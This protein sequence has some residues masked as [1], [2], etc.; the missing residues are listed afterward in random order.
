MSRKHSFDI[1][2]KVAERC[3]LAC[4]YCYYFFQEFD[5]STTPPLIQRSVMER[6]PSFL[7]EASHQLNISFFNIILHGGEPLLLKKSYFDE[8][9]SRLRSELTDKV[10]FSIGLQTNGVLIDED[11]IALFAKHHVNVGVSIDGT[12]E[13]HDER[14]PDKKGVGSYDRAVAGLELL[15]AAVSAGRLRAAGA[16]GLVPLRGSGSAFLKHLIDTLGVSSPGLNFPR[17]GWDSAEALEWNAAV[18]ARRELASTWLER[19]IYP[20][21]TYISYLADT[22]FGLMSDEGAVSL[23][24]K[25]SKRHHIVTISSSGDLLIDDNLLGLDESLSVSDAN[26]FRSSLLDFLQSHQW[27]SLNEAIDLIPDKCQ[28][29][30][31]FRTCRSGNL[32]NRYSKEGGFSR[33]SVL[34]DSI[35]AIHE[36]IA[37]YLVKVGRVTLDELIA[38]LKTAPSISA[39]ELYDEI[40]GSA[41]YND[42]TDS[43]T[44]QYSTAG[45]E[46]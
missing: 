33:E 13:N 15:Q 20:K 29:C 16:L 17:G 9:C 43:H 26:I 35:K 2:L 40:I 5:N 25:L 46:S 7:L 41:I 14:R 31:W 30:T 4:S 18:D 39:A 1:V 44:P 24:H 3:N 12:K 27:Q 42:S 23:D 19:Y 34:C 38:R 21:F 32:F 37:V 36:E 6:L 8:I 22:L 10:D 28:E 11:W 45:F